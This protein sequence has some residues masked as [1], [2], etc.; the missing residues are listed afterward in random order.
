MRYYIPLRGQGENARTKNR[1]SA[2]TIPL[3]VWLAL[4]AIALLVVLALR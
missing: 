2:L 3:W 4:I 1:P